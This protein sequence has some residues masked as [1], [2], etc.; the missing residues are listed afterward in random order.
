MQMLIQERFLFEV[1]KFSISLKQT[2]DYILM[3]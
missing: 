1:F 2:D 3:K